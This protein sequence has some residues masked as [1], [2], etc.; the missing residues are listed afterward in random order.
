MNSNKFN[1][2]IQLN[3]IIEYV[4]Y[5]YRV[6]DHGK[7]EIIDEGTMCRC[8]PNAYTYLSQNRDTLSCRDKGHTEKYPTWYSYGRTQSLVMPKY[9]LFF[10]KIANKPLHCVLCDDEDL[11][12]YNGI[13][14]VSDERTKLEVLKRIM[15][16]SVFWRYVIL[17]GKPYS[18]GY[19]SLN[20]FNIK[21]F[22]IPTMT[23]IQIEYLISM[24]KS[25]EID[26]WLQN[27]Y[28]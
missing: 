22:G 17:N 9:K 8:F 12:L 15:E 24:D 16:S 23:E 5:P 1:S 10:P 4:I 21:K 3:D 25:E 26:I 20:G 11:L 18:S 13:S 28:K 14:F 7:I 19:Y 2:D 27:F 6:N